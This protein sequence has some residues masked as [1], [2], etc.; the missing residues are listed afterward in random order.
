MIKGEVEGLVIFTSDMPIC[1]CDFCGIKVVMPGVCT[2]LNEDGKASINTKN[3]TIYH[4]SRCGIEEALQAR[5]AVIE[6]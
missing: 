4:Q 1:R 6:K 5:K 2:G 3:M